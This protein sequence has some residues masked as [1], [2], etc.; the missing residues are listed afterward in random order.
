MP[1][2]RKLFEPIKIGRLDLKNRIIMSAMV[3]NYAAQDGSVTDR[4]I[5][6]HVNIAKGGCALN[7]TGSSYVS[8]EGKRIPCGSGAHDDKLIP[9]Y[10]R[11]SDAVHAAGGRISIQLSHGGRECS[12]KITGLQPLGA[13]VVASRYEGIAQGIE[14]PR[15]MT[16]ED[17]EVLIAKFGD[18]GRRAREGGFDAVEIHAGHG[19][20][21]TQFLSP[22]T[23]KRTDRYGGDIVGRSNFLIEII[24]DVK[25]KAGTD[26]PVLVKLNVCDYVEGGTTPDD[27]QIT[28]G[29]AAKE[30]ADA[31]VA[32]VGLHES[33]PQRI[34]PAMSL[35]PFVNI[36]L[37]A[38][39]KEAVKIPVAAI[40]RIVEPVGA[41]KI[42]EEGKADLVALGRAL[43]CD[44]EW[45]RKAQTG[46]FDD[47]R[48]CIGCNQGCIDMLRKQ[49]P[50]ACLQNAEVGREREFRIQ[51]SLKPKRV[52]IIGG[53]P[54][55]LEAARIAALRGHQVTVYEK[56][57]ELGG[58]VAV[59]RIPP[60]RSELGKV[61]D[62][63]AH[64]VK[65]LGI[66]VVLGEE[67]TPAACHRLNADAIVVATGALPLEPKIKGISRK[68]VV[69]AVDVLQGKAAIGKRIVVVGAGL[70]GLETVDFCIERGKE[71][72][73]L[74]MLD[75]MA[76]D[77]GSANRVYFEDRFAEKEVDIVLNLTVT[78][79][80]E[81]D[82]VYVQKGSTKKIENVDTVIIAA[83]AVPDDSLWKTMK[84]K[85]GKNIFA[86]GDCTKA[87]NVLEAIYEGSKV[88]RE[89]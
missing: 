40:G 68:H 47:I 33:R 69:Y 15:E 10:R 49:K 63:L 42:I 24:R 75:V 84:E 78:E 6:Y 44:P 51:K 71:V 70:V 21:I 52:A 57:K 25:K 56:E 85:D 28:A 46:R 77:T 8:Q 2:A 86:I 72:T 1:N 3:T 7:V 22:Y 4:L 50:I 67:I 14:I 38:L 62:Y 88:A 37:A 36:H 26:F 60:H 32:S 82:V 80:G 64:Q 59:G 81:R 41:A 66:S 76:A 79:I 53:G 16:V 43:L 13:T 54:A 73:V 39:I 12:A 89:I 27:A 34:V 83:G 45:P 23:N 61:T 9:G 55:G 17:I 19:Y 48:Q 29:L 31:I 18:A 11:L 74:E 30:G 20:V 87:R 58:Q 35:P 65:N 5:D